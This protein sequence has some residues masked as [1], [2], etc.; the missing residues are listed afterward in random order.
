MQQ[1]NVIN[2][3]VILL[4]VLG[5]MGHIVCEIDTGR[6]NTRDIPK[7]DFKAFL[8]HFRGVE[9]ARRKHQQISVVQIRFIGH[10]GGYRDV[11]RNAD[12]FTALGR[13]PKGSIL[14]RC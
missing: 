10:I 3:Q 14:L 8:A 2:C 5:H 7:D 11:L 13:L 12:C 9:K 4:G 1:P 6:N